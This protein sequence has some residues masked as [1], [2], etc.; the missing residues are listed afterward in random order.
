M[1]KIDFKLFDV[2]AEPD[3]ASIIRANR[4]YRD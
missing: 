1:F 4:T 2:M 3:D